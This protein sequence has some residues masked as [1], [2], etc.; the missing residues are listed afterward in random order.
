MRVLRYR[1][2]PRSIPSRNY[3]IWGYT[4]I[5]DRTLEDLKHFVLIVKKSM[6]PF[7]E[8][9]KKEMIHEKIDAYAPNSVKVENIFFTH[10]GFD[11]VVTFYAIDLVNAKKFCQIAFKKL[12]KHIGDYILLETLIPM[13]KQGLKNPQIK[14]LVD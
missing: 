5:T 10:G 14:D 12:E 1:F 9:L 3:I 4:P 2:R 11:V 8:N 6:I 7:N 13:R